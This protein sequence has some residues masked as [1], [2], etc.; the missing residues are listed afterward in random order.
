MKGAMKGD[1]DIASNTVSGINSP[2]PGS[3]VGLKTRAKRKAKHILHIESSSDEDDE[4]HAAINELDNSPAFNTSKFLNRARIGTSGLRGKAVD[5]VQG[6]ADAILNPKEAIKT[7]ATKKTAGSLAK[8]RPFLSRKAD[9]EFL[10]A[11]DNLERAE[12]RR[13]DG[14]DD[15][16]NAARRKASVDGCEERVESLE[17]ARQNM[18]VAWIT[19][20][21]VQRVR[22]VDSIPPAPFPD[23][24]FFEQEDDCGFLEFN[25]GKWIAYVSQVYF[26][27]CCSECLDISP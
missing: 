13:R 11:H 25:W 3:H 4:Y 1:H 15:E 26:P 24:S 17:R 20:R 8:S 2:I 6:T 21:H 27:R 9:L 14:T 12:E 22:V 16:D 19:A 10:E 5:L 18:R 7:R 23:D